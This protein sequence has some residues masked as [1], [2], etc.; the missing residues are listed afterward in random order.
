[1]NFALEMVLC[2]HD[3]LAHSLLLSLHLFPRPQFMGIEVV[4]SVWQLSQ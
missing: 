1:M 2:V 4:S 3:T